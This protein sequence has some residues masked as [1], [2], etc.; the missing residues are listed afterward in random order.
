LIRLL[1]WLGVWCFIG[2]VWSGGAHAQ[3]LLDG[4]LQIPEYLVPLEFKDS[5]RSLP[6]DKYTKP[7]SNPK[8]PAPAPRDRTR[9]RYGKPR[10]GLKLSLGGGLGGAIP[11]GFGLGLNGALGFYFDHVAVQISSVVV[12]ELPKSKSSDDSTKSTIGANL[13]E[14]EIYERSRRK[15][16]MDTYWIVGFGVGG[17]R[18]AISGA[19]GPAVVGGVGVNLIGGEQ[20]F[21]G[22]GG[23]SVISFG[24][25]EPYFAL[26]ARL[27]VVAMVTSKGI[28]LAVTA[29]LVFEIAYQ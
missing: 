24:P 28:A 21:G 9:T 22:G 4:P 27:P 16:S 18:D 6:R 2:L 14:L 23:I 8:Q 17:Y 26:H 25:W 10:L 5:A 29:T 15:K 1:K 20:K 3:G 13:I 11:T 12:G 7:G 19:L